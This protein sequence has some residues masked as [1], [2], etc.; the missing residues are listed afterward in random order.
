MNILIL[1]GSPKEHS[2]TMRLTDAFISGMNTS[3]AHCIDS[4][5]VIQKTIKPCTGCFACWQLQ[6]GECI[7]QDDQNE[8][9]KKMIASDIIIYSFPLYCYGMPSHLKAVVDR[10]IPLAKLTMKEKNGIVMHESLFDLSQ[11]HYVVISGCGFPDWQGNF[12]ALK[13]QCSSFFGNNL[14][15]ICVPEAPLL[16]QPSA[17]PLTMPLLEK[18]KQAGREYLNHFSLSPDTVHS[19]ETPMLPN[20]IYIQIV[21]SYTAASL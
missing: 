3:N 11:K 9:L 2:T 15:M 12:D 19:L 1:N 13:M 16:S 14:T 10:T 20:D 7:Q 21:N 6:N 4:V 17:D 5:H 8:L 18:F